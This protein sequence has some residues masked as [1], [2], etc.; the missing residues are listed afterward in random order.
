MVYQ[1]AG[2]WQA[3]DEAKHMACFGKT[4]EE[5]EEALK[6]AQQRAAILVEEAKKR[7]YDEA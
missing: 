2:G 5:A 4:K 1:V 3:E 7:P 6:Q